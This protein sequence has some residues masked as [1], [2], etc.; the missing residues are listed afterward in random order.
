MCWNKQGDIHGPNLKEE[1]GW[2]NDKTFSDPPSCTGPS[3]L[4][5]GQPVTM[6]R[7]LLRLFLYMA[8]GGLYSWD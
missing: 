7:C 5:V 8:K 2:Q 3:P 4:R 1:C 6:E